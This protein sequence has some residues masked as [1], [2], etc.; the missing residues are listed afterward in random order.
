MI[1]DYEFQKNEVKNE[2]NEHKTK[3]NNTPKIIISIVYSTY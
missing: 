3:N 1:L 2:I